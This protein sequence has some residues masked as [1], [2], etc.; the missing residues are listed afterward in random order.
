[1]TTTPEPPPEPEIRSR[2]DVGRRARRRR[3]AGS[4]LHRRVAGALAIGLGLL[5]TAGLYTAATADVNRAQAQA[6][7]AALLQRGQELYNENACIS[8][9]GSNLQGVE[10][11]GPSLIGVGDAAVYFQ[12]SS[13]RMPLAR[14]EAQASASRRCRSST[15]TPRRARPTWTP[16][17]PTSRP[18]AAARP[19]RRRVAR[20]CAATTRRAVASCSA[21][22]APRATTS[23]AA[24][25]RCRRASTPRTWTRPP[26]RRSTRRC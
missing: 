16:S 17:A 14:Q 9:H 2:R 22:T 21:S 1:M 24:A 23:P 13:G 19:G 12:V 7:D 3:R 18:T 25:A 10:D 8:C 4:R 20:R 26:R 15:R 11:R 6:A 5:T